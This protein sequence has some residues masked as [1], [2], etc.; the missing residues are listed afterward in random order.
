MSEKVSNRKCSERIDL[1]YTPEQKAKLKELAL[2]RG[3]SVSQLILSYALGGLL[4]QEVLAE[5]ES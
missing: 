3:I 5:F 4:G 2:S 1:R